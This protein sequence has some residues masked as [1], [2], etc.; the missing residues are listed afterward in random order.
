M[1]KFTIYQSSIKSTLEALRLSRTMQE[2][3]QLKLSM[4]QRLFV[5]YIGYLHWYCCGIFLAAI[6]PLFCGLCGGPSKGSEPGMRGPSREREGMPISWLTTPFVP[7]TVALM[8]R[9][10]LR[11]QIFQYKESAQWLCQF[12]WLPNNLLNLNESAMLI[13]YDWV[14][15]SE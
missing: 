12:T 10:Y 13:R 5:G 11:N 1:A 2:K 3:R 4:K 15:H 6:C 8:R 14:S 7:F 9:I